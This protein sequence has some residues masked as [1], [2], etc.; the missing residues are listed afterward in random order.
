VFVVIPACRPSC[1]RQLRSGQPGRYGRPG[2]RP[3]A[4]IIVAGA[5]S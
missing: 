5:S 2:E 3:V 1:Q 4:A